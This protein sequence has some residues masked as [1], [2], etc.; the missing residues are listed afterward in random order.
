MYMRQNH[1]VKIICVKI[2][3]SQKNASTGHVMHSMAD[4]SISM[5]RSMIKG[6]FK[7][8]HKMLYFFLLTKN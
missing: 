8:S 6:E 4:G 2:H 5:T 7:I 1:L 3:I